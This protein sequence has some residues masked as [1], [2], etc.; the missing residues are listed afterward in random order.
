MKI[1]MKLIKISKQLMHKRYLF[2]K[3]SINQCKRNIYIFD[4]YN[5]KVIFH[6]R[7]S[8][9]FSQEDKFSQ[10]RTQRRSIVLNVVINVMQRHLLHNHFTQGDFRC[11]FDL[12]NHPQISLQISLLHPR[13]QIKRSS[14]TK[15]TET[16]LEKIFS[17]CAISSKLLV[18][19]YR[20][21]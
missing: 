13:N 14:Q 19:F 11:I 16:R 21:L 10:H 20:A 2:V 12:T 7:S 6:C 15:G 18:Y 17:V 1:I 4:F 5:G 8:Y 9:C 3:I